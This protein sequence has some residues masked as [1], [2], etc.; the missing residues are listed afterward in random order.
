MKA[1]GY[2]DPEYIAEIT[3]KLALEKMWARSEVEI[4]DFGCGTGLVGQALAQKQFKK[5]H[6]IDC[7]DAMIQI[8]DEKDVY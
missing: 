6:G 4:A 5:I 1:V 8:A 2:P 3:K 7:S